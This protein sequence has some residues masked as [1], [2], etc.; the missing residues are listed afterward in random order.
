MNNK[1]IAGVTA[2]TVTV[3]M[4][5]AMIPIISDSSESIISYENNEIGTNETY[6]IASSPEITIS[7]GESVINVNDYAI[8][9]ASQTILA[10][11]DTWVVFAFNTSGIY[12][13]YD[14]GYDQ[15]KTGTDVSISG[16]NL[17]YTLNSD[18]SEVTKAISGNVLYADNVNPT[19]VS[20]KTSA[21]FKVDATSTIYVYGNPQLNNSSLTPNNLKPIAFGK[22]TIEGIS[23]AFMDKVVSASSI[24]FAADPTEVSGHW[25]V[26][27]TFKASV[28]NTDGTYSSDSALYGTYVPIKYK[29]ITDTDTQ[30]RNL[31]AVIPV[32]L[33]ISVLLFAVAMVFRS[34]M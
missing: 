13:L 28:T 11:C 15:V 14:E 32:M 26:S 9:P 7:K 16:G 29:E 17:T 6:A 2:I 22:G 33:V 3:I 34:R 31:L 8:T 24:E 18:S 1:L 4:L 10:A 19:Y 27:N 23:Y 20:Y 21:T 25:A 30:M 12:V 5:A